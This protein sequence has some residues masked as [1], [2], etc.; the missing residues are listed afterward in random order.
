VTVRDRTR[1]RPTSWR[2]TGDAVLSDL[3][4]VLADSVA[5]VSDAW[6]WWARR[7]GIDAEEL[8]AT[9]HG[10]RSAETIA[11]VVRE[12][13][14]AVDVDAEVAA[15]E[16]RELEL[17]AGTVAV[18]G[19]VAFAAAVP[20]ERFAV[21]TSGSRAI[22]AARLAAVGVPEPRVFVTAEDVSAGKP[23]PQAYLAA[24][25]RLGVD[26]RRCLVLEDTP[27]GI[28][29]GRAAGATVV[30]IAT[31]HAASALV[32][33]DVVVGD[34]GCLEVIVG[35]PDRRGSDVVVGDT[36]RLAVVVRTGSP[37]AGTPGRPGP[38]PLAIGPDNVPARTV[39]RP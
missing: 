29:A 33:A 10:V 17:V 3:D 31:T 25:R 6:A 26:P 2:W 12:Q 14:L 21:V 15:L 11:R 28:A 4:G 30:G 18:P 8:L 23:D 24:A 7:V 37:E 32:A 13:T 34:A 19:A 1:A 39:P 27:A 36:D 22:A 16:R 35:D 38:S 20:P 9:V 5:V